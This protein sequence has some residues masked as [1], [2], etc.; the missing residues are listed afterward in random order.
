ME[1]FDYCE[2]KCAFFLAFLSFER[3]KG[4]SARAI[5][6]VSKLGGRFLIRQI[7]ASETKHLFSWA[8]NWFTFHNSFYNVGIKCESHIHQSELIQ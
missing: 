3:R 4:T 2:S 8:I 1:A 7:F 6:Q 5:M